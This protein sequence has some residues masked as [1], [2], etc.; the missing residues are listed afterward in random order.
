MADIDLFASVR[1]IRIGMHRHDVDALSAQSDGMLTATSLVYERKDTNWPY[2]HEKPCTISFDSD[3]RVSFV[4][5]KPGLS[6]LPGLDADA[7]EQTVRKRFPDH[8]DLFQTTS[9]RKFHY[10]SLILATTEDDVVTVCHFQAGRQIGVALWLK[11]DLEARE[12]RSRVVEQ[13]ELRE[14]EEAAERRA[15]AEAD[16]AAHAAWRRSAP[17]DE[18]LR[19]WA[20][21]Y[22]AW[23][24]GPSEWLRFVDWLIEESTPFDRHLLMCGYNWGHGIEVP[25]WIVRQPDTQ[26]ATV[27]TIFWLN[28]PSYY[29]SL[30][31]RNEPIPSYS[32]NGY[33]LMLAI[34][35]NIASG[36]YRSPWPWQRIAFT[37]ELCT[38]INMS[39][40]EVARAA[41]LLIPD[42]ATVPITGKRAADLATPRNLPFDLGILA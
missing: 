17:P 4:S 14:A 25:Y 15:K 18:V 16:R 39:D 7:D 8:T 31:A 2:R 27:L 10:V 36:F 6:G 22:S 35:K 38:R 26:L 13:R 32:E 21:S 33:E 20:K 1:T 23:G 40:P 11:K 24:E 29:L 5:F 41:K 19:H 37:G 12:A 3:D 30:V 28:E 34:G 42:C 9:S